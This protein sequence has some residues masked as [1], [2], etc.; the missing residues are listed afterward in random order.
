M[1]RGVLLIAAPMAVATAFF[2]APLLVLADRSLTTTAGAMTL[3]HYA[4][5][6]GDAYYLGGL[7]IT[8]GTAGLVTAITLAC[9][10]PLALTYWRASSRAKSIL[11]V[12]LLSPFYANVVVKVFGWMLVLPAS[13]LNGYPGLLIVSVHRDLPFMVLLLSSAMARIEP[14]WIESAHTCGAGRGR[15]LRTI[16]WPLSMP[17]V[18]AGSALVFSMTTAAYVAPAIVGGPWRGRF[19]PVLLYQQMTIAQDW[20]FGAV[21]GV[22]LLTASLATIALASAIA[23][24]TRAGV[25]MREGFDA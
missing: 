16:I 5:F 9:G 13:W 15:V 14:E 12:L 3:A 25:L 23:R 8:L 18:V 21:I 1:K 24:A 17:G 4:R 11:I 19:L 7:A 10:Y 22:V 20:E 2:V 6:F